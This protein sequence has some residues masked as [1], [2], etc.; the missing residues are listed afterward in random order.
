MKKIILILLTVSLNTFL[1]SCTSEDLEETMS[2]YE[3]EVADGTGDGEE[4]I[5]PPPPPPPPSGGN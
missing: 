5:L 3:M 2:I 4:E 1:F